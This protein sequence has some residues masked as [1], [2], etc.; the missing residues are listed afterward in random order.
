MLKSC[1]KTEN[2]IINSVTFANKE[3][4]FIFTSQRNLTLDY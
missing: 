3:K 1:Q 2:D 4:I